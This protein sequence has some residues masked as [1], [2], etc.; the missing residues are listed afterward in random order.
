M[1]AAAVYVVTADDIRRAGARTL[2]EVFRLVPGVQVAQVNANSWAV[3]VRGF[4]DLVPNKLLVLI[5]A[6]S[7]YNRA[8][9]GVFW[10]TVDLLV[11]DIERVEVIRG[12]GG[13]MWGANAVNGVIN[14]VTKTAADSQ[15][16]LVRLEAGT[17]DYSQ[18]VA[19]YGGRAGD[20]SYR[21]YSQWSNNGR[22]VF[23]DGWTANDTWQVFTNGLRVDWA[24]RR[25]VGP[26]LRTLARHAA[27]RAARRQI[28]RRGRRRGRA[29]PAASTAWRAAAS[30]RR[31]SP[32]A[33][34]PAPTAPGR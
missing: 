8:H 1:A 9:S 28:E 31:P 16:G 30:P 21:A 29:A 34:S 2:P 26:Q 22:G 5:D 25:I 19:R 33:R 32:Q 10:N 12:P 4:N 11:D 14:V 24:D 20:L 7:I 27:R 13:S 3:S 18:G 17:S 15:G 23:D 6:R